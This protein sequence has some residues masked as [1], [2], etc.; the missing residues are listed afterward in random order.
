VSSSKV[1]NLGGIVAA[2]LTPT[3]RELKK[4]RKDLLAS[5]SIPE[6]EFRRLGARFQLSAADAEV[7][8]EIQDIDYLLGQ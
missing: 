4:R 5:V 1:T 8:R 2:V 3:T 6:E 7:L